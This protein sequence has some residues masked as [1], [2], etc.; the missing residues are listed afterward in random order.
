MSKKTIDSHF[1]LCHKGRWKGQYAPPRG[2]VKGDYEQLQEAGCIQATDLKLFT[3]LMKATANNPCNGCPT[4]HDNGPKCGAFQKYHVAYTRYLEADK[5][6]QE[7]NRAAITPHNFPEGH[8][9]YGKSIAQVAEALGKSKSW[10]R[11]NKMAL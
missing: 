4:W 10:V 2:I 3:G 6:K 1:P 9:F 5:A 11:S 7:E 8:K